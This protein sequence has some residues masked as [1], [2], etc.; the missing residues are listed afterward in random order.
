MCSRSTR[1]AVDL[2]AAIPGRAA[3]GAVAVALVGGCPA[4]LTAQR[5]AGVRPEDTLAI[6]VSAARARP[7]LYDAVYNNMAEILAEQFASAA[8]VS[9]KLV[10]P[11]IIV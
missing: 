2:V 10:L 7:S 3:A 1:E 8:R 6:F 11:P 5:L 4:L 9:R